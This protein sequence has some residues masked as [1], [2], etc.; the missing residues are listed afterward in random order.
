LSLVAVAAACFLVPVVCALAAAAW[1]ETAFRE[2]NFAAL[3]GLLMGLLLVAG[4]SRIAQ[5]LTARRE[6]ETHG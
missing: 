1:L 5:A 2:R 6:I 3:A 4:A